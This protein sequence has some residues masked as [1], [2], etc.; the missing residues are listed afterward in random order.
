[1]KTVWTHGLKADD[2][3]KD[4]EEAYAQGGLLRRRLSELLQ[5][6]MESEV[7]A[8]TKREDYDSPSWPFKQADSCGYLR[9]LREIISLID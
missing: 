1:M 3:K 6:K 9:A 4:V 7:V 5:E 2:T 8:R